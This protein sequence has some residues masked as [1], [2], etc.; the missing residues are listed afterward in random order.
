[1]IPRLR[2]HPEKKS[3]HGVTWVDE[4][5]WIHQDNCLEILR[6]TRKLNSE[7]KKYLE[8]ENSYTKKNMQDTDALQKKFLMK[9]KV[10]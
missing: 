10:E 5:S 8:D 9:L 1:M 6:D 4:Y 7:V 3:C 2:K